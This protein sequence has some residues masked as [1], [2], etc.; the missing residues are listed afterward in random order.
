M[1]K[2]CFA[3]V[4]GLLLACSALPANALVVTRNAAAD[5]GLGTAAVLNG[6]TPVV[7]NETLKTITIDVTVLQ[8]GSPFKLG[9][10]AVAPPATPTLVPGV[11]NPS[12]GSYR[13]TVRLVNGIVRPGTGRPISGFDMAVG[14]DPSGSP[15]MGINL[16][17]TPTS[18]R[19]AVEQPNIGNGFR[20][21]GINGGGGEIYSGESSMSSITLVGVNLDPAVAS[22]N[23]TLSFVAN[24]E[25]TTLLL[26]AMLAVPGGVYFR[27]RRNRLA[28]PAVAE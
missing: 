13:V 1:I 7:I 21:G 9:F 6:P 11:F 16:I 5:T 12:V 27:R 26:G 3:L 14:D 23:F 18:D 17:P 8:L 10:S 15:F 20:F 2:R 19:F 28:T 22:Q 4:A 24:P 25:P